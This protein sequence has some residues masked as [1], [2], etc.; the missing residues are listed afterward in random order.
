MPLAVPTFEPLAKPIQ[1][2]QKGKEGQK[3]ENVFYEQHGI[4]KQSNEFDYILHSVDGGLL[5]HTH[6]HPSPPLDEIDLAFHSVFDEKLHGEKLNNE[7]DP[8][9]LPKH[10]RKLV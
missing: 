4:P 2:A 8:T 7:L 9:H 3:R 5:L 6:Q 1:P 10:V